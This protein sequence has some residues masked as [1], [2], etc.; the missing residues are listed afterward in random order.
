VLAVVVLADIDIQAVVCSLSVGQTCLMN[1]NE[2]HREVLSENLKV[3]RGV[4][5]LFFVF[6]RERMCRYMVKLPS[7]HLNNF[8]LCPLM[9]LKAYV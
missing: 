7:K 9:M 2:S 5:F 3:G 1:E 6:S 4:F 8:R